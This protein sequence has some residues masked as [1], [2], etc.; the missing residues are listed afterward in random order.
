MNM[1][2]PKCAAQ[3]VEGAHFCRACGANISLVSQALSG[4]LPVAQEDD[5]RYSKRRR[6]RGG[7]PSLDEGVRNS[8]MGIGFVAVAIS[9]AF[10]GRPIGANVWWF[11]M[12]IPAFGMLSKGIS[13]IVRVRQ[14]KAAQSTP[15]ALPYATPPERLPQAR[16]N[17]TRPPV[18]SV[19]EGTTRHLGTEAPAK[20]FDLW[21]EKKPS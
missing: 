7:P 17:E 5:D 14:L 21:E 9:L 12:L 18:A 19:T 8:I 6:R 20:S 4:Q 2:C 3:N 16:I 10:F 15:P 11:W 13:D 1:F